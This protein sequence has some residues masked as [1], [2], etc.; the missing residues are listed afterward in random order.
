M[1]SKYNPNSSPPAFTK[2][3]DNNEKRNAC[4]SKQLQTIF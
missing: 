2:T 1:A 4:Q 3:C